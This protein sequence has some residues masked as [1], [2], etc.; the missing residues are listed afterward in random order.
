[1]A[2]ELTERLYVIADASRSV[3]R[4]NCNLRSVLKPNNENFNARGWS[5]KA[6]VRHIKLAIE[7]TK[8]H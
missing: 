2:S 7:K 3:F 1:M 5:V 6:L 8:L 4:T